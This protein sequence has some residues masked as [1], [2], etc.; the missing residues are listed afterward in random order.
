MDRV[1]HLDQTPSSCYA[2]NQEIHREI[3][4]KIQRE[5]RTKNSP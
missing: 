5:G 3:E 2:I 4:K 1:G